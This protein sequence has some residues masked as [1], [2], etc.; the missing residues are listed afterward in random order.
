MEYILNINGTQEKYGDTATYLD[1]AREH[2]HE[3]RH[4]VILALV[5]NKL[6]ELNKNVEEGGDLAF[7]TTSEPSGRL[8]YTRGLILL[9]LRAAYKVIG[10][11]KIRRIKVEFTIGD[12]LYCVMDAD[13]T[14]DQA[15][16]GKIKDEMDALVRRDIPFEKR[17]INTDEA[18]RLFHNYR[19]YDKERLLRYRRTSKTN[20]YSLD[21]FEDYFYGYMP[22]STGYLKCFGLHQYNGGFFL[23]M[24][25]AKDPRSLADFVPREKLFRTQLE[26]DNFGLMMG[27]ET[28]GLLND[29][30]C[31]RNINDLILEQEAL[32]EKTIAD[33]AVMIREAKDKK[34]VM[35]AGPSSSGKTTFSH[36]LSIQLRTLGYRPHPIELDNYFVNREQTPLDEFG[37]YNYETLDAIDVEQF[38]LDMAALLRGE[39][40]ELPSFNFKAG[41][42]EYKGNVKQLGANDILIIE[43]IHGLN[44]RL[45]HSLPEES[46]FKIYISALTQLNID[47]HNRI[48]SADGRLIRRMV[49]DARTR[50]SVARTTL[51][52][53][54]SVRKGEEENIFPFQE[55]CDYMFNSALTY[56]LAV[57][58][59]YA[60]PLLFGIGA[61]C[62]EYQE[63]KRLLKFL[64]YFLGV[65]SEDIPKNSIIREFIGGSCFNC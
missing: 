22:P 10:N 9:M 11:D 47:E 18:I 31:N 28:V 58:K 64:D 29:Y 56:E 15:L 34:F 23:Q 3:Y 55:D 40:V 8:T 7:V 57:L 5:N 36:R 39:R 2:Q 14:L 4:D 53:W 33:I 54:S 52:M 6:R 37:N 20:I 38:N 65:T 12:G 45:S 27:I 19:M 60:E 63:A 16:I 50:G 62:P 24:P 41:R 21:G 32:Q 25:T 30:I 42:R 35:I 49:R 17:S 61:E 44:G 26:A 1:I 51:A 59:Q 46:K 13:A 48:S 43:G